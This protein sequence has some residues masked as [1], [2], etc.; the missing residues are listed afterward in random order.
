[1]ALVAVAVQVDLAVAGAGDLGRVGLGAGEVHLEHRPFA[2]DGE[3]LAGHEVAERMC[4]QL[5]VAPHLERL[6]E[7]GVV[8][9]DQRVVLGRCLLGPRLPLV[10][11]APVGQG[12]VEAGGG[13][14]TRIAAGYAVAPSVQPPGPGRHSDVIFDSKARTIGRAHPPDV[15]LFESTEGATES[16]RPKVRRVVV[17]NRDH[18]AVQRPELGQ[19]RKDV[20]RVLHEK[21]FPAPVREDPLEV[22][23]HHVAVRQQLLYARPEPRLPPEEGADV[24]D[25]ADRPVRG[26]VPTLLKSEIPIEGRGAGWRA[27]EASPHHR[28]ELA[29]GIRRKGDAHQDDTCRYAGTFANARSRSIS[30]AC[31]CLGVGERVNERRS[32]GSFT[33]FEPLCTRTQTRPHAAPGFRGGYVFSTCGAIVSARASN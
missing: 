26:R 27:S 5:P 3:L 6:R 33:A 14:C 9:S 32:G 19:G 7:V 24:A 10:L 4:H 31:G 1:M 18:P 30:V 12:D 22:P 15:V 8:A 16:V 23:H 21:W 11:V 2:E 17:G 25:E 20:R 28:D 13:R 29:Q